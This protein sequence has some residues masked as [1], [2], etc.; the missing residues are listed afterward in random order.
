MKKVFLFSLF[1]MLLASCNGPSEKAVEQRSAKD[2]KSIVVPTFNAD[3]AYYFV[4]KQVLFGPRVPGTEAHLAAAAWFV[5]KLGSYADTLI[6]QRFRTRVYNRT[7]FDGQNIIASFNPEAKKRILLAAHWDS[8]PYADFDPVEANRRTPIDGANDGASG[9]GVLIE[10]ARMF[11][12]NPLNKSLGVDII[13][14]DLEDYGPHNDERTYGD[15]D[16]WALGSQHWARNMH[17]PAY[18]ASY[19]ILLDMVGA[20][21][22]VFPRE[23][24]SQQ[25][26]S[27][28][29]DKVWRRASQLGYGHAFSNRPGPP[30]NDDHIPLNRIAGIPTINIIH[31]DTGSSNG[32][33]F[34]YWHTLQD[35]MDQIDRETLHMVGVLVATVVYEAR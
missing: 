26:A 12:A 1:V 34:E 35:N 25:Y 8:R 31:L 29:L 22:A 6:V 13:L 5:Q 24:Y 9:A 30:I 23:Y 32:S 20:K 17:R 2:T 16:Y 28:V 33:F 19:G 3:S 27:W 11:S 4:E 15:D 18:N 21:G 14:F 10:L 7:A